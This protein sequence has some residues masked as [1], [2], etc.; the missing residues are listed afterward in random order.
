M[1]KIIIIL[2][3]CLSYSEIPDKRV[4]AEWETALGTMI[5]WP[6]GIPSDLVI[7]LANE[8]I[9][10]VLVE[11]NNQ[12]NQA[13]NNFNNWGVNF[14][15]VVFIDTDTYSHWTRDYGPQFVIGE[16][17]WKVVNQQFNG[18]PE[19]NGCEGDLFLED[20]SHMEGRPFPYDSRGWEEDDD[21]NVDFANQMNWD[22]QNLPL[23]LT[24]GNFM[25]DGY[26][27]GFST[28][29][30][31]NE[32][33]INNGEFQQ[34]VRDELHL[35]NYHIFDNPNIS[36]IQ[37][38]DC[39][40][41]LVNS[42]TIIIKKVPESSPEY[43]CIEDFAQSFYELN[44][45]YG[46]PF[47]IHRIY[48]PDINGGWWELNSVA[49]Y[50]NS[51]ILNDKVLVPQY[52]I[53]SDLN[54]LNVY[55]E[56]MPGY[57]II[58]FNDDTGNPWYGEDALHCRAMGIFD[59]NMIHISHKSIRNEDLNGNA[60]IDIEADIIDYNNSNTD[61]QSVVLHWKY[62]SEDGPFGEIILDLES[63]NI[64][65]GTF[66]NLNSN[67]LIKYFIKVTNLEGNT[68]SHPN[69]GWHTF[70]TLDFMLGDINGDNSINI[71]DIVLVVNLVL[72]NE[73]NNLADLNLDETIN[74]LDIVQLV[75][76]I[77][78]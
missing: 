19:E 38:I 30:M 8:E 36:S 25:T 27:M 5:S 29:L 40:A 13:T 35:L 55:Q 15:N 45:F 67:S 58:G 10:Y 20:N 3:L 57:E 76:I 9:L 75:N 7:E 39:L 6:L 50:T 64:Y 43:Q 69:A 54:A 51:L 21:T 12:Q 37:H 49:A 66:P 61:L 33:N 26:G 47:N 53:T 48:C 11:T 60:Y 73:Y 56:A 31:V 14:D 42:E 78:N 70:N 16:D 28:Q 71:Q 2:F 17:Y 77:L 65:T 34:I 4:V 63:D 52:G 32:N 46:R 22:I 23:Y 68:A 44:T 1:K 41:K 74:V 18:Y 72:S 62:S 59:P 24:G